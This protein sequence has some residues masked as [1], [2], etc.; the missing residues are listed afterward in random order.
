MERASEK[1][2]QRDRSSTLADGTQDS[3]QQASRAYLAAVELRLSQKIEGVGAH[4][5]QEVPITAGLVADLASTLRQVIEQIELQ[6]IDLDRVL[7]QDLIKTL[8]KAIRAL[9]SYEKTTTDL[10]HWG[11]NCGPPAENS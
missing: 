10:S 9:A 11:V 1:P 6:A 3:H 7:T 8:N 2:Q 4:D 5:A